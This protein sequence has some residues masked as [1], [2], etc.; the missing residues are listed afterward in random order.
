MVG[1]RAL[2]Q[3]GRK[4]FAAPQPVLS[5]ASGKNGTIGVPAAQAATRDLLVPLASVSERVSEISPKQQRMEATSAAA[6]ESDVS[7]AISRHVHWTVHGRPGQIGQSVR[8]PVAV[9]SSPVTGRGPAWSQ[10]GAF[11][12]SVSLTRAPRA[13]LLAVHET[14]CGALGALGAAARRP[15]VVAASKDTGTLESR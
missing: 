2:A 11:R 6:P 7:P 9:A 12:A 14:A 1:P 13:T 8:K 3:T 4:Q 5:I 10:M 15:V